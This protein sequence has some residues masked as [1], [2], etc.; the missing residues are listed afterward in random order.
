MKS[1]RWSRMSLADARTPEGVAL[2]VR[3]NALRV[4]SCQREH[5]GIPAHR[6]DGYLAALARGRIDLGTV[7][8]DL[9]VRVK[10]A[11][12]QVSV[13]AVYPTSSTTFS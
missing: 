12:L 6:N 8:K 5:T 13:S 7:R 11:L 1:A 4:K 10:A 9:G 3:Q 2:A